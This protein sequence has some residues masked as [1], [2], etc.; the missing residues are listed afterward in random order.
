MDLRNRPVAGV[1][2]PRARLSKTTYH[3]EPL[4]TVWGGPPR[5]RGITFIPKGFYDHGKGSDLRYYNFI[6]GR[7]GPWKAEVVREQA[8]ALGL[9]SHPVVEKSSKMAKEARSC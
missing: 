7:V 5:S 6:T 1:V 9:G 4:G 8:S 3:D 2:Y